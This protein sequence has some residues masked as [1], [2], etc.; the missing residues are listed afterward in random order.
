M[1]DRASVEAANLALVSGAL[2]TAALARAG[3]VGCHVRTDEHRAGTD[4]R[5]TH[6][7]HECIDER[8]TVA[9]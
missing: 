7:S 1:L 8:N 3:S 9:V 6:D 2:L 4:D 5:T